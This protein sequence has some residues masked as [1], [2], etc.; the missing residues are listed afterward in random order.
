MPLWLALL[1]WPPLTAAALAATAL[2]R[3]IEVPLGR[4]L[5]RLALHVDRRRAKVARE[6]LRRCLPELS[7]SQRERLVRQNFEHYGLLVLELLHM[8]SPVPGHYRRYAK[9]VSRLSGFDNW[10]RAADK[11]KGV[12]FASA[13]M[14]NWELMVAAGAMHGMPL[15]M[16][17]RH[18]K[19]EWL[20]KR[21]EAA[22]LSVDVRA[23]YQPRTL[24]GVLKAL[25]RGESVGFVIDQYAPPPMGVPALFFG[26]AVDTLAAVGPI[27]ERTGAAVV[28]VS[29]VREGPLVRTVIEPELELPAPPDAGPVTQVLAAKVEAWVRERPA[30]WLWAHRRFKNVVWPAERA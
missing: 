26:V 10:R 23:L 13:H 28:P 4:L 5:G 14:G 25:R 15:T 19:P 7:A 22:R 2:P 11:G 30:H 16:V 27:V 21:I 6:N 20:H 17:T 8:L 1:I 29:T 18:L 12:I 3:S 9:R 24:P